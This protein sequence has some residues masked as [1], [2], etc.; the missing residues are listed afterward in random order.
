[1]HQMSHHQCLVGVV[2]LN[3]HLRHALER[4]SPEDSKLDRTQGP[5]IS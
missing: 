1:V 5:S 2:G 3:Y 4:V